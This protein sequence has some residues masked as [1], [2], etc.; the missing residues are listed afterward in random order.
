MLIRAFC[1][2]LVVLNSSCGDPTETVVTFKGN[3]GQKI[4]ILYSPGDA[5]VTGG[6]GLFVEDSIC[7]FKEY[8]DTVINAKLI[9]DST[10]FLSIS[11]RTL[12]AEDKFTLDTTIT[13]PVLKPKEK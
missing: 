1:F 4:E 2:F 11:K 12:W 8:T 3:L 6:I 10:V 9:N 7:Y 5:T 13:I